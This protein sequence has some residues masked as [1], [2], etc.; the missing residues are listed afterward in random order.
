MTIWRFE[1][2]DVGNFIRSIRFFV[3]TLFLSSW[4]NLNVS[5]LFTKYGKKCAI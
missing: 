3:F 2:F 5:I 1:L 4:E